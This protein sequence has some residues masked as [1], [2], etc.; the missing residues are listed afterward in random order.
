MWSFSSWIFLLSD[1]FWPWINI[2]YLMVI[3]ISLLNHPLFQKD[4]ML[5]YSP[6][7]HTAWL[8]GIRAEYPESGPACTCHPAISLKF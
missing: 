1:P 5:G 7:R 3:R 6:D 4:G 8:S 2:H